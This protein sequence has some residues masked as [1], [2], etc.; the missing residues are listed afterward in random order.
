MDEWNKKLWCIYKTEYYSA[1]KKKKILSS[2][3]TWMSLEE[4][5][6]SEIKQASKEKQIMR[7][8]TYMQNLLKN[9]QKKSVLIETENKTVTA[10]NW[11]WGKQ[12]EF[13]KG[14]QLLITR[15]IRSEDL[16][17]DMVTTD[18]NTVSLKFAKRVQLKCLQK[19]KKEVEDASFYINCKKN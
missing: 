16:I 2:V 7:G 19:K 8:I 18:N 15:C 5:M 3:M 14:Y 6:L 17:Y 11:N 12:G 4:I 13:G 9:K 1:L 10:K